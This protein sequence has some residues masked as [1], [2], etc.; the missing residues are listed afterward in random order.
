MIAWLRS[1]FPSDQCR[2]E[3]IFIANAAGEPMHAVKQAMAIEQRGLDG[4]RYCNNT[5]FWKATDSCPVTLISTHDLTHAMR[6]CDIEL[7]NG[8]HRRNLVITG[9]KTRRLEGK[10]FRIGDALFEYKRPRPPCGYLDRLAGRG[11]AK[12]MGKQ[13]GICLQVIKGGQLCVGD[14]VVLLDKDPG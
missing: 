9:L 10:Q 2:L 6:R 12:A 1:L 14:P 7:S 5:G 4:D 11:L 13:A 8:V 3:A